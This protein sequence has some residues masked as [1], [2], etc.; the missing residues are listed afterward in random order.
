LDKF[1][2]SWDPDVG[3]S[4]FQEKIQEPTLEAVVRLSRR[5]IEEGFFKDL[6][7]RRKEMLSALGTR[8]FS[9][10]T[11]GPLTLHLSRASTLE[12]AGIC[13]HPLYGFTYLPG[14]GLKG[15]A[16]AFAETIWIENQPAEGKEAARTAIEDVFGCA[17]K[18]KARAGSVVFYDAW[19]ES[20]PAL[21][22]DI[23]NNHHGKYYEGVDDPGDWDDPVP[24]YFLSVRPDAVFLFAIG[25]RRTDTKPEL[26]ALAAEWLRGGL[27]RLG[28]GAKTNAGY[29]SF[30]FVEGEEAAWSFPLRPV[31][32]VEVELVTPAFLAGASQ[33]QGDCDL[34]PATMRGLLR[35]WW[36]TIHAGHLDRATLLRL[37]SAIWGDTKAGGAVRVTVQPIAGPTVA[38][39]AYR[40]RYSLKADFKAAHNLRERPAGK[41]NTT[42]GLFYLSYGMN[43]AKDKPSRFYV[44]P[45]ARWIIRLAARETA[46]GKSRI[47]PDQVLS[48]AKAALWLLCNFGGVG[49]KGR[50]GFG[51]LQIQ[52][53]MKE[54]G[55]REIMA[56][57]V[58][59]R[60]SLGLVKG[61]VAEPRSSYLETMIELALPTPWANYW[62][63]LN[64]VGF[65]YQ[66]FAQ[67]YKHKTEKLAL[68]LPRKIH[69]PRNDPMPHQKPETHRRPKEL[70]GENRIKRHA[71]PV[72]LHFRRKADSALEL[73]VTAFPS[74]VLPAFTESQRFLQGFVKTLTVELTAQAAAGDGGRKPAAVVPP[75][76]A[77]NPPR[78]GERVEAVLLEEKTNKRKWKARHEASGL[79]GPVVNSELMPP[80]AKPGDRHSLIVKSVIGGKSM[81]FQIPEASKEAHKPASVGSGKTGHDKPGGGGFSGRAGWPKKRR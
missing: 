48:Q 1:A 73:V 54:G 63:A 71:S 39:Y 38:I 55:L 21:D 34:R 12:N 35:W 37:E 6:C 8:L 50:K 20:W 76:S 80:D 5:A 13:L 59:L 4:K 67:K 41:A 25:G 33:K 7:M 45:G 30:V 53:G 74:A 26:L 42:P 3:E 46:F 61:N 11:S 18:E 52:A 77:S 19:P 28:A 14:S 65:A 79:I 9:G 69:G 60:N 56:A 75:A 16:R 72:H 47:L 32:D 49:S 24:V 57:A 81:E 51:S 10:K 40:D 58:V 43:D 78:S 68:G 17:T 36:R 27:C 29:G 62:Y 22:I 2:L 44:Q 31:C 66:S 64:E 23:V 15:L 70:S